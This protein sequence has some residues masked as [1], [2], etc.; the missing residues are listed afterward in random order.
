M[1]TLNRTSAVRLLALAVTSTSLAGG[2]GGSFHL[3][4]MSGLYPS[5]ASADGRVVAGYNT[6]QFWYWTPEQGL[7]FLGGVTPSGG[8]AGSAGV[9]DDGNRIGLTVLNP[10]TGKTEGA[11][12]DRSSGQTAPIGS[13]GFS[14][15]LGATSCWGISG[16]GTT[17]VGLGWHNQCA[18]R[19]YRYTVS[20][21]LVDLGSTVPGRSSRANGANGNGTVIAGWQDSDSGFRQGA[22][23]RNGVQKLITTST[24]VPVGEAG[25]VSADGNWVIGQGSS[26]NS[27]RGWR[28]NEALGSFALPASPIPSL[29]RCFPTGI[30]QDGSRIVLFYRT[31]FPPATG[32]EGYLWVDGTLTSLETLAAQA[33]ITVPTGVRMALPLGMSR[34]GYTIVGTARTPSGIQGFILDLPRPNLCPA[35]LTG[36]AEVGAKDLAALLAAWGEASGSADIDGDGSVGATDLAALLAAWGPCSGTCGA[37]LN[38]DQQVDALDLAALLAAWG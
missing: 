25:A 27:F 9:S 16:D 14:C 1:S 4:G 22:V 23:W 18:A 13:F 5:D 29:P 10:Q 34:D 28:W 17:M 2:T 26:G 31:Q 38:G 6:S 19:A 33:G 3:L 32:G 21:G 37:D 8:G 24:G 7:T 11:F 30:S 36:D 20:G 35:D 15:D 12:H